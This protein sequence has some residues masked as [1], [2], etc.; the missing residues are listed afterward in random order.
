MDSCRRLDV[1]WK[2]IGTVDLKGPSLQA[3]SRNFC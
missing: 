1:D 2:G 3:M